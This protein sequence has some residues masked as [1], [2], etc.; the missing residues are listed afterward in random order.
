[1]NLGIVSVW[2]ERGAGYVSKLY[3]EY[4]SEH[5][6]VFI[7]NRG[8]SKN[9]FPFD[10]RV[11]NARK[12]GSTKP[13]SIHKK[14]FKEWIDNNKI[15]TILF[16]EQQ[17]WE[18]IIWCKEW[19]IKIVAYIDYYTEET[20][21]FHDAYDLLICNTKRHLKAFKSHKNVKYY[22][23]GTDVETFTPKNNNNKV[24][25]FLHSCGY[26]P[27]RKGTDSLIRAFK[28]IDLDYKLIIHTQVDLKKALPDE[29][30]LIEN[31]QKSGKMELV[32][33][34][35]PA[36]G[37]YYLADYYVY[38][39]KLEGIGLTIAESISSGMIPI[40]P[41]C[42]PMIEFLPK[43]HKYK[44]KVDRHVSR[45]DGYYW[46]QCIISEKHLEEL[47]NLA[48]NDFP[49]KNLKSTLRKWAIKKL[50]FRKNFKNLESE[51]KNLK[52]QKAE[53][54]LIQKI[55]MYE[56]NRPLT[57]K[58]ILKLINKLYKFLYPIKYLFK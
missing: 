8:Y 37:L 9:K 48:I 40:I 51:L 14:E 25:V 43:E 52:F 21:P 18:P 57:H 38:P 29:I 4:L 2:D 41:N 5:F 31:L 32:N 10:Q 39:T 16:N 28:N 55:K 27:T 6:V 49:N 20:V 22:P 47:I 34:T 1:M 35:I 19:K 50:D 3:D 7:Y 36:P 13:M 24:P 26:S 58:K 53:R 12:V 44:I 42:P 23:W 46:P 15:E 54:E 17:S 11:Y 33:K 30:P 45:F 56:L